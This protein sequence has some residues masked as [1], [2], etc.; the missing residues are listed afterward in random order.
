M[1][2]TAAKRRDLLFFLLLVVMIH[3]ALRKK[4]LP[5][6]HPT[7]FAP[8]NR[9]DTAYVDFHEPDPLL[10]ERFE[11]LQ[12]KIAIALKSPHIASDSKED[13]LR[14]QKRLHHIITSYRNTHPALAL[15][16]PIA[17]TG[18]V[19]KEQSLEKDIAKLESLLANLHS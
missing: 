3:V 10:L 13:L 14:T 11:V 19:L 17:S 9:A 1:N 18:I 15:L 8:A 6:A 12:N 7:L 4:Q 2:N 5:E 16:G